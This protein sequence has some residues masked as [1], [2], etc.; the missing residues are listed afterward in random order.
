[1]NSK[2]KGNRGERKIV[3]ILNEHFNTT[4][5]GR[6]PS[7]GAIGTVYGNKLSLQATQT[8]S[9]DIITPPSFLFSI[10]NKCGYDIELNNL[11]K[12]DKSP[13]KTTLND[14][15]AQSH[16]DAVRSGKV[17]LVIYSKDRRPPVCIIPEDFLMYVDDEEKQNAMNE[18]LLKVNS[19]L[20]FNIVIDGN[21]YNWVI[22]SFQEF[23]SLAPK[24]LFF[25][26]EK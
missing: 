20:K 9:G 25:M 21:K 12:E 15:C 11:F 18:I 16:V 7:S 23:L 1:M 17:P 8:L 13:D 4:E 10:E 24:E 6:V 5:F 3:G 2:Q 22:L 19:Y 14:F 26:G